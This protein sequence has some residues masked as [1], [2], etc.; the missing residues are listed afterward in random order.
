M[1]VDRCQERVTGGPENFPFDLSSSALTHSHQDGCFPRSGTPRVLSCR[2][3]TRGIPLATNIATDASKPVRRSTR[4]DCAI[5]MTISGVDAWRGPYTE[6]VSTVTVNAHGCKYASAHQVL[7][8]SV[9]I[10][11]LKSERD[12]TARSARGRVKYVKRPAASGHMFETAI[13]LEHPGN[14]WGLAAPP[15][16]WAP[17]VATRQVELDTSKHRPFTLSGSTAISGGLQQQFEKIL[18][19]AATLVVREK[20]DAAFE[21]LRGRID[22]EVRKIVSEATRTVAA[23]AIEDALKRIKTTAHEVSNALRAHWSEKFQAELKVACEQVEARRREIDEVAESLSVS[24]LEKLQAAMEASR[25]ESVDRIIDR[26]KEESAP[27]LDKAQ[28]VIGELDQHAQNLSAALEH[29][30][31][32]SSARVQEAHTALE[33]QFEQRIRERFEAAQAEFACALHAATSEAL[34]ELRGESKKQANEAKMRFDAEAEATVKQNLSSL[35]EKAAGIAQKVGGE[36]E[37]YSQNHLEL[38]G[39]AL[40]DLAKGLRKKKA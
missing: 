27:L 23:S 33:R 28:V 14:I 31:E 40:S 11:E 32:E 8:D 12:K 39:S 19:G 5:P 16:D 2:K 20:T 21:E 9:V 17:F 15:K 1:L 37:N 6:S 35:E 29:S 18:S 26:L 34:E 13:E 30:V 3:R 22:T 25:R 7:K 38:V 36:L 4:V 10:L 24:A